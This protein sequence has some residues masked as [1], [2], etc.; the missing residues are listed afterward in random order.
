MLTHATI[1]I[2]ANDLLASI[3]YTDG[4]GAHGLGAGIEGVPEG[5]SITGIY[6]GQEDDFIVITIM[7]DP[8]DPS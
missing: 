1:H 3:W 6:L 5:W 2:T 7:K 8:D 4:S